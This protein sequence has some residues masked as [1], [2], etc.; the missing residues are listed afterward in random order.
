MNRETPTILVHIAT[1]YHIPR[2][3]SAKHD[4]VNSSKDVVHVC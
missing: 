2:P 1:L 4:N 3:D